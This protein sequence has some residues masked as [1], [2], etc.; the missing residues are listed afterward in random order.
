MDIAIYEG[1]H[2]FGAMADSLQIILRRA[3]AR[4]P[5][6]VRELA[7]DAGVAHSTLVRIQTGERPASRA[8]VR[9]VARAL[10]SWGGR[11]IKHA[12]A[13]DRACKEK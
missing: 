7:R 6:T 8:V 3:L 5:G 9:R 4:V 1:W 10:R 13:L 11:C 12:N 2:H